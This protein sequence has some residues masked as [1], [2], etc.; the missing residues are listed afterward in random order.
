MPGGSMDYDKEIQEL[1]RVVEEHAESLQ[2]LGAE[3]ASVRAQMA[4]LRGEIG[5]LRSGYREQ[6]PDA[7]ETMIR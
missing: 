7:K 4:E 6:L 2:H 1:K 3:F 5:R